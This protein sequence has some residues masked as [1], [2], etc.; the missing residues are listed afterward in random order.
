MDSALKG[1]I[2]TGLLALVALLLLVIGGMKLI[3]DDQ[4]DT[5]GTKNKTI[6]EL[7]FNNQLLQSSIE[8]QNTAI[9]DLKDSNDKKTKEA[10]AAIA[11]A[12]ETADKH[13]VFAADLSKQ[14]F[15]GDDCSQTKQLIAHYYGS[16]RK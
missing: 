2:T 13:R 7:T 3:I 16:V 6:G 14:Q 1:Y 10:K 11:R 12:K 4:S 9:K 5:I 8:R 15:T